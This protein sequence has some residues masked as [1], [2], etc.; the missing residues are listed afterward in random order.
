MSRIAEHLQVLYPHAASAELE[1]QIAASFERRLHGVRPLP[2]PW[3]ER[4][5]LLIT[6]ADT[7]T[8][9]GEPPLRTLAG[10]LDRRLRDVFS[11]VHLLPYF[12]YTSDD[13]F[14]V[15][16]YREVRPDLGTWADVEHIAG[17]FDL[18]TDLVLNHCSR[19]H[20]LAQRMFAGDA[21]AQAWFHLVPLDADTS[22]VVRPR[23]TPLLTPLP[24]DSQ[25]RGVW[26]T[27]GEDQ[28]D[29][30]YANPEV[31]LELVDVIAQYIA[32]GTRLLRLDA[33]AYLWKSLGTSSIHLPQTHRM[34]R[35]LR[36]I[37]DRHAPDCRLITETNVPQD[38][39]LS[40]FGGGD[41]ADLVYQ[42]ALPSLLLQALHRGS[43]VYLNR[44]L[45]A[46]PEIPAGCT[47]LN[48]IASHDGIGVRPVE[49]IVTT[50]EMTQLLSSMRRFGGRISMRTDAAGREHPY[51]VN[52]TLFDALRGTRLGEDGLQLERM[53]CAHAILLA[54]PG[55]PA[56]YIH[57]LLG[58]PNDEV[59]A[60]ATGRARSVNRGQLDCETLERE[61]D[62]PAHPRAQVFKALLELIR[63]RRAQPAFAPDAKMTPVTELGSGFLALTREAP[64]QKIFVLC[65]MTP[66][67]Q[68]LNLDLQP[69]SCPRTLQDLL[70]TDQWRVRRSHLPLRLKPYQCRWLVDARQNGAPQ[71]RRPLFK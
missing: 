44:W 55:V 63:I 60:S 61:L 4:D 64:Q 46:W 33:V 32:G 17:H 65:N 13:G 31:L 8:Q 57:A 35:L 12:P 36:A 69:L 24:D 58:S 1:Q 59:L 48:F 20:P 51:E 53:R 43:S 34:V 28:L 41:E 10:F 22:A 62:D 52:I 2:R 68:Q 40:Y 16:A 18:M 19:Q 9:S 21:A 39:N 15:S 7:L 67:E 56:F 25:G 45:R 37:L 49:R 71:K 11:A 6:Y 26:T 38:E 66:A 29:F 47:F 54:L 14:A 30:N 50:E 42:F 70:S 23:A 5:T 3:S 27:F